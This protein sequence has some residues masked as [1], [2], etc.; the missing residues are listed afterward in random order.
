MA[1]V[2][3]GLEEHERLVFPYRDGNDLILDVQPTLLQTLKNRPTILLFDVSG[4][5]QSFERVR[6][7]S[8]LETVLSGLLEAA[9][10][11]TFVT[12]SDCIHI[13][14]FHNREIKC[15][16]K[17]EFDMDMSRKLAAADRFSI[18]HLVSDFSTLSDHLGH[19]LV[20]DDIPWILTKVLGTNDFYA[21]GLIGGFTWLSTAIQ[22]AIRLGDMTVNARKDR[23]EDVVPFPNVIVMGDGAETYGVT[24]EGQIV[25]R[26][27][28][29]IVQDFIRDLSTSI[30]TTVHF[31]AIANEASLSTFE[32]LAQAG[33]GAF[34]YMQDASDMGVAFGRIF[35]A[36]M[37]LPRVIAVEPVAIAESASFRDQAISLRD[38]VPALLRAPLL[39]HFLPKLLRRAH[40]L[41]RVS[42]GAVLRLRGCVLPSAG[43][44]L[45][46]SSSASRIIIPT[47]ADALPALLPA[48]RALECGM[49]YARRFNTLLSRAVFAHEGGVPVATV[50]QLSTEIK[51]ASELL[52]RAH[53]KF[54]AE[55]EDDAP[56]TGKKRDQAIEPFLNKALLDRTLAYGEAASKAATAAGTALWRVE[57]RQEGATMW[58]AALP[59]SYQLAYFGRLSAMEP[60]VECRDT[61]RRLDMGFDNA[62]IYDAF[63]RT[64]NTWV[65][66]DPSRERYL[67]FNFE[68]GL[69]CVPVAPV[70]TSAKDATRMNYAFLSRQTNIR[71]S[72]PLKIA[73]DGELVELLEFD[74]LRRLGHRVDGGIV[75][76]VARSDEGVE[77]GGKTI[78]DPRLRKRVEALLLAGQTAV[79]TSVTPVSF[80]VPVF[81]HERDVQNASIRKLVLM[82]LAE[83]QQHDRLDWDLPALPLQIYGVLASGLL[84]SQTMRGK[85]PRPRLVTAVDLYRTLTFW[86]RGYEP[87]GTLCRRACQGFIDR[88][89]LRTTHESHSLTTAI[90][91]MVASAMPGDHSR[92]FWDESMRRSYKHIGSSVLNRPLSAHPFDFIRELRRPI[93]TANALVCLYQTLRSFH[94]RLITEVPPLDATCDEFAT[95]LHPR[96]VDAGGDAGDAV[97]LGFE[98]D[99]EEVPGGELLVRLTTSSM[100]ATRNDL[101]KACVALSPAGARAVPTVDAW[102]R[103]RVEEE[104]EVMEACQIG[105]LTKAQALKASN[106]LRQKRGLPEELIRGLEAFVVDHP[107][108]FL[109]SP[110]FMALQ[111]VLHGT[112]NIYTIL[113]AKDAVAVLVASRTEAERRKQAET[114]R[115]FRQ[116]YNA[117][118]KR[119]TASPDDTLLGF[120]T[121]VAEMRRIVR[122]VR[123]Q[124]SQTQHRPKDY[125]RTSFKVTRSPEKL[126]RKVASTIMNSFSHDPRTIL[127]KTLKLDARRAGDAQ[128]CTK[129]LVQSGMFEIELEGNEKL[130]KP[131]HRLVI[132]DLTDDELKTIL[133]KIACSPPDFTEPGPK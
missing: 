34:A 91:W 71:T 51:T 83:I 72:V 65:D 44:R 20:L 38:V 28:A 104:E 125:R 42:Q 39:R 60:P 111:K 11:V 43:L 88:E 124:P 126:T 4:S 115:R 103:E 62:R 22:V 19:E 55:N 69:M 97:A 75:Q 8:S 25:G 17:C 112:G 59:A 56:T 15:V 24:L 23:S 64:M 41:G 54:L 31:L 107:A 12:F 95:T 45:Y 133:L 61:L 85:L 5:I 100:F 128:L 47:L 67:G 57:P 52:D 46:D 30:Q 119:T 82:R 102:I 78:R 132:S 121:L 50:A 113:L 99:E 32:R 21:N 26:T 1:Q 110:E 96:R 86:L 35:E 105:V 92:L 131:N 90:V 27:D 36:M 123:D 48:T 117:L 40:L 120:E 70:M 108:A 98:E 130:K 101:L 3:L 129:L 29:L 73:P 66:A 9:T 2:I 87:S 37:L 53:M 84:T 58:R 18:T 49:D 79:R 122:C 114:E 76:S 94:A 77:V 7:M 14:D 68:S 93:E 10:P 6:L 127:L 33:N 106:M 116:L 74:D 13:V 16:T 89:Q 118:S 80:I 63:K 81:T 109:D